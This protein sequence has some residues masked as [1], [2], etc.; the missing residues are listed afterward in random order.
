MLVAEGDYPED[1]VSVKDVSGAQQKTPYDTRHV[2]NF[3][4]L[5]FFSYEF[6]F[7]EPNSNKNWF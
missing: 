3:T 2:R 6:L 5:H 1:S 7:W 4:R